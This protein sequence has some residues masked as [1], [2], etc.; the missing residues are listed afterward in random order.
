MGAGMD[1]PSGVKL[2]MRNLLDVPVLF[3]HGDKDPRIPFR[4]SVNTFDEL[5]NLKPRVPPEMHI[6]KGRGHD[7]TLPC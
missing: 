3:L 2:P 1:S 5:R 7:V 6:L 4:N